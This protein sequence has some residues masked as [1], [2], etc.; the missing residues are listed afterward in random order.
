M[1]LRTIIAGAKTIADK[2]MK[3]TK[4]F[5]HFKGFL[6]TNMANMPARKIG[7]DAQMPEATHTQMKGS[8]L[9]EQLTPPPPQYACMVMATSAMPR[10]NVMAAM[11]AS[12]TPNIRHILTL[13]VIRPSSVLLVGSAGSCVTYCTGAA[14]CDCQ[15]P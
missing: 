12:N 15:P 6:P 1:E 2:K 9:V 5:V 8:L 4:I 7:T 10:A 14:D 13:Q 3:N 11:M